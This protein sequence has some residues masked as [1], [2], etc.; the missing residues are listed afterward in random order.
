M[1]IRDRTIS[2]GNSAP[3]ISSGTAGSVTEG[4]TAGT[5]VYTAVA[6]G[7]VTYSLSGAD[8]GAFSIDSNTG[9]VTI[10]AIPDFEAKDSYSIDVVASDGILSASKAVTISV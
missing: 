3:V 10:N 7:S 8:A 1:C 9:V 2:V 4:A 6:G 5:P